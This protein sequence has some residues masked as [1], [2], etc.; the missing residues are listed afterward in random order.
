MSSGE[1]S[2]GPRTGTPSCPLQESSSSSLAAPALRDGRADVALLVSPF[3]DRGLELEPLLTE[4]RLAAL[5]TGDPLAVRPSLRLADLA[6]RGLPDGTV[7]G[8]NESPR[9]PA[10][11]S[12]SDPARPRTPPRELTAGTRQPLSD[13]TQIFRLVELGHLICFLPA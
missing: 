4:P 11:S 13:I 6:G 12:R 9:P 3:D 5:A 7:V 1:R 10:H 8:E 2:S